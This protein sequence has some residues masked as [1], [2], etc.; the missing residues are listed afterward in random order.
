VHRHT[1]AQARRVAVRAQL[2]DAPRPIDLLAVVLQ[3]TLRQIDP[4]AAIAPSAD[5]GAWSRLGISAARP[6]GRAAN[7][8]VPGSATTTAFGATS[9]S[10]SEAPGR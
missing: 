7:A 1:K 10:C 3:L 9:W 4:T 6:T 2:L 5:L 8:C